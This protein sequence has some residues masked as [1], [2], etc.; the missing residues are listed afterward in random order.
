[1]FSREDLIKLD[2]NLPEDYEE[3][4][5]QFWNYVSNRLGTQ[6]VISKLFYDSLVTEDVA[7]AL[8]F[9]KKSKNESSFRLVRYLIEKGALI[10]A[11]EDPILLQETN[12]WADMLGREDG[13]EQDDASTATKELLLQSMVERDKFAAKKISESLKE[14]ETSVL[15][16]NPG[17]HVADYFPPD[18]R[19]IR[20][21]PFDPNDYVNSWLVSLRLKSHGK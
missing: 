17:R 12:S 13:G 6:R 3:K 8:E 21:Q 9:I 4:S 14:G 7:K 16:L 20:I 11:T 1:M 2:P 10:E 18:M 15:F 19:V 5:K